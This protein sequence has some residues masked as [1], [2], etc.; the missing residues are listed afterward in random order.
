MNRFRPWRFLA[1][2]SWLS[3]LAVLAAVVALHLF[4][5]LRAPLPFVDDAWYASRALALVRTGRAYGCL[6]QGVFERYAG[7]WTILPCLYAWLESLA[8]RA[9]GLSLLTVRLVSLGAGLVLSGAVFAI[10]RHL[11]G[12][13]LGWVAALLTLLSTAFMYSAH[14]ARPDICVAAMGFTAI[15]LCITDTRPGFPLRSVLSGLCVGVAFELN[16]NGMI[17]GPV[18]LGLHFWDGSWS[19]LR[20]RRFWGFAA[21]VV[22]GLL[23]YAALHILPYPQSYFALTGVYALWRMPPAFQLDPAVWLQSIADLGGLLL[24]ANHLRVPLLLIALVD[25]WRRGGRAG[26]QVLWFAA[27][28]ALSFAALIRHKLPYDA[29]LITPA[30]DLLLAFFL[31]RLWRKVSEGERSAPARP[32]APEVPRRSVAAMAQRLRAIAAGLW[33]PFIHMGAGQNPRLRRLLKGLVLATLAASLLL[34]LL[35]LRV[36]PMDDFNRT[37]ERVRQ[38][39]PAGAT[40]LGSQTYWFGIPD[41][42]YLSWEQIVY[43]QQYNRGSTIE[44][45]LRA[46]HPDM[47]LIDRHLDAFITDDPARLDPYARFLALDK[48]EVEDFLCTRCR[49]VET[50]ETAWWG[51]IRIYQVDWS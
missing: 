51:D 5:L 20:S 33:A 26:R 42:R 16:P 31:V 14:L 18:I 17:Y 2:R 7:Y 34:D 25:L 23:I 32:Y 21:G 15:A 10:G 4:G 3:Q 24:A 36:Q 37:L 45:A 28:L 9:L 1:R 46:L 8:I 12:K 30:C 41:R 6:D 35:P 38:A 44:D 40:I 19:A 11:G 43:Y 50:I 13:T 48:G 27:L 39:V 22:L 29:I 49:L 47:L